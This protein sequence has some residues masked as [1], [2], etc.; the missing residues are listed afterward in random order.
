MRVVFTNINNSEYAKQKASDIG[1]KYIYFNQTHYD[2][3]VYDV[4]DREKFFLSVMKYGI[5]FEEV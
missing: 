4:I 2:D 1:V 3:K 5:E